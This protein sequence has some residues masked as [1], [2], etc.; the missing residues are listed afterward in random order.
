[1]MNVR[2]LSSVIPEGDLGFTETVAHIVS[3]MDFLP[4]GLL[5]ALDTNATL[6]IGNVAAKKL[7]GLNPAAPISSS[8]PSFRTPTSHRDVLAKDLPLQRAMRSARTITE[9]DYEVVRP[10]GMKRV[11]AMSAS[12]LYGDA[13]ALAGGIAVLTDVTYLRTLEMT[14]RQ[15]RNELALPHKRSIVGGFASRAHT[16]AAHAP[17]GLGRN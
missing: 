1:M 3:I 8:I 9:S 15:Q 13:E 2:A 17:D 10:D 4:C 14:M 7:L 6:I 16:L 11:V 5:V 12:P